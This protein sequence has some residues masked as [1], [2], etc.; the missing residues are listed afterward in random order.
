MG[1]RLAIWVIRRRWLVVLLTLVVTFVAGAGAR[2]LHYD[3]DYRIWFSAENPQLQAFET[4][5]NTYTKYDNLLF[6][7]SPAGGDV[8][9]NRALE[10]VEWLTD[11]AWQIP[12]SIRVDSLSNFQ[13]T[14]GEGDDL[15]VQDLYVDAAS[16]ADSELEYVR[17]V[18]LSEPLLR[19]RLVSQDSR[20]QD[21]SR[22]AGDRRI[23]ARAAGRDAR[24]VL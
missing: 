22:S 9:T 3:S 24:P 8:F 11:R 21:R 2:F 13:H 1:E 10:A 23:R 6:V 4:I 20:H 17:D 16:L 12:Y 5:Q 14:R 18:A 7:L 19:N 15:I